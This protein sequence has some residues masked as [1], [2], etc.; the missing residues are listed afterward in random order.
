MTYT[1]ITNEHA[2]MNDCFFA[3]STKQF[4]EGLKKHNLNKENVLRGYAGLFG[5][6]EGIKEFYSFYDKQAEKIK[7]QCNP[8]DVYYYEFD[9][10][11][12]SYTRDDEEA[13]EIVIS[14][15]GKEI[16]KTVK[17]RYAYKEI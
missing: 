8:Q 2:V 15:F 7:N 16:A 10:H 12:C 6:K 4:N 5:T 9:N 13:I 3:F 11:E 1:E 17:R 14:Y